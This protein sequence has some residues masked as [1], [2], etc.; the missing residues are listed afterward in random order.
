M[1]RRFSAIIGLFM[2]I[3]LCVGTVV[4]AVDSQGRSDGD[5]IERAKS[6]WESGAL[7]PALE[8]LD[9]GIEA[10]PDGVMLYKLR[11]DILA[12][13]RASSEALQAYEA[14]LVRQPRALDVRWAKWSLLVR[15]GQ[16]GESINELRRIA[17]FDTQNPLIHFRLARELRKLDRLEESL[18]SYK[19]AVELAPEMLSWRLAL[20]RARFDVLDYEGAANDVQYVLDR[21]P[22][23]SPLELPANTLATVFH[24]HSQ[25][26]GR[27][28]D[29]VFT[30]KDI[31]PDQLKEWAL[32]RADAWRMFVAGRYREAEPMYRKLLALNPRDPSAT[33]QFGLTLMQ[34]GKCEEALPV[35]GKVSDLDPTEDQYSDIVF[36]MGQCL[37]ELQRWEEAF[38]HFHTLYEQAVQF[39]IQNKDNALPP[40]TRVLDKKKLARWLDKVRPHVPAELAALATERAAE[41]SA[42]VERTPP[43]APTKE[44]VDSVL[45]R[46]KPERALDTGGTLVGRD[47]DFSWFRFVIPAAKVMRDD[48]PTG[49]HDFIPLNPSDSFPSTTQE[50]YLVFRLVSDSYDAVPLASQCF[51]EVAEATGEQRAIAQDRV[52][53]AMSDQSGYFTL[54][55]PDQGW[56]PG[57]YRC[58]LFAGER[59]SAY[60]Q[61]DEVRFR[62]LQHDRTS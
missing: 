46:L 62:I 49:Q 36:R 32:M 51:L 43:A 50:I 31:N 55:R 4:Y 34:L 24:G 22:P 6:N 42:A 58:G 45:D 13:S 20:A 47:A 39:E 7:A 35:F 28:F 52:M 2:L 17:E 14:V 23:D 19:K 59:T 40:G 57:L 12:T 5:I 29:P 54:G 56:T 61:A 8:A 1:F 3:R 44:E 11:G 37:V 48:L 53:M 41:M 30:P 10:N 21:L 15:S 26:R 9:Q 27:R 60:T 33:H 18:D 25:D 38:M 16:G